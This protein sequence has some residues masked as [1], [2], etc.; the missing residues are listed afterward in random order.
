MRPGWA[1]SRSRRLAFLDEGGHSINLTEAEIIVAG[2]R[3]LGRAENVALAEQLA[4]ALG[5]VV[6]ASR[7]AVDAGWIPYGHQVGQTGKTVNPKLY[8]A[9]GISGAVQHLVGMSSADTIVAINNDPNAPIFDVATHGVVGDV[10]EIIPA[11]IEQLT[12][13]GASRERHGREPTDADDHGQAWTGA[14][15]APRSD[16]EPGVSIEKLDARHEEYLRD[17]S[18]RVGRAESISFPRT[19]ADIRDVLRRLAT[20]GT[21]VTT[22]GARTGIAGGAVPAGGHILNLSR[23][24]RITAL[25]QDADGGAF[26]VTVQPGVLLS[27]LR[28][29]VHARDFR[30]DGW[31]EKSMAALDAF[32]QA[33]PHFFAPD[34]TE[35]SA[36]IGGMVASNASGACSFR[37]G[38]TGGHVL[39]LRVLLPDGDAVSLKRGQCFADG[40]HFSLQLDSGRTV[41][42]EL[43]AYTPPPV[44]SAA[45]YRLADDMDLLD[46]FMG[47]EGTL[48]VITEIEVSLLPASPERW[49]I[50]AFLPDEATALRLVRA[51]RGET[52]G[53]APIADARPEAVEF[54]NAAAL[55][56]LCKHKRD[57]PGFVAIPALPDHLHTAIYVEYQGASDA[58][59]YEA[60]QRFGHLLEAV[61]GDSGATWAAEN[62]HEMARLKTF[63]HTVPEVVNLQIDQRRKKEPELTKLGTDMSVPDARLGDAMEMYNRDVAG[64]GLDA[65]IFGHIGDNHVHVNILPNTMDEYARGKQLYKDWARQVVAWGGS[66]SAEHG[67]GKLKTDFLRLMVGED[68]CDQMRDLKSCFDPDLR[69]NS[70]NLL[71]PE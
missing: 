26:S 15:T 16:A 60:V 24:N 29:A 53:G 55:N 18:R 63:R 56:L 57:N 30:T 43:P 25:R 1:R 50:L 8:I 3:G 37:H 40:R 10:A 69:L 67:I 11:L 23:M 62:R 14:D 9:C 54:F 27:E 66:V 35:T 38:P 71:A 47:M 28:E 48:G 33:P 7:G 64:S 41:S 4:D 22:Q 36:S 59:A 20:D 51:V 32:R 39:G 2:G 45:G 17:E 44:K 65:V 42:G 58:D 68:V 52:V 49:G 34:P 46:L 21:P 6:G 70:G 19:E 61:G 31:S 5:G 13:G 12:G